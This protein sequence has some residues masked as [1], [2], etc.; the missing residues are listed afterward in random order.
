MP[1]EDIRPFIRMQTSM[2]R[3]FINLATYDLL[4]NPP[5]LEFLWNDKKKMLVIAPLFSIKLGCYTVSETL[6]QR[7]REILMQELSFFHLLMEKMG[8]RENTIYK[9]YG[10][11]MPGSNMIGFPMLD[12]I[13][14][15]EESE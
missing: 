9:V 10:D 6:K 11:L 7:R 12:A 13:I 1:R 4:G 15:G 3:V 2:K 8:W 14:T 5:H